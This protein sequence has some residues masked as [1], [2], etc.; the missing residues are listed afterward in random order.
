MIERVAAFT[1][2][3]HHQRI[4]VISPLSPD[5]YPGAEAFLVYA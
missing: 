2:V 3:C 4:F 5:L 1:R